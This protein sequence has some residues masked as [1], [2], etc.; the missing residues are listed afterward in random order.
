[1]SNAVRVAGA[2][3]IR[4]RVRAVAFA[5]VAGARETVF[6]RIVESRFVQERGIPKLAAG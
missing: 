3:R 2:H 5:R 6:E 1:M 4:H